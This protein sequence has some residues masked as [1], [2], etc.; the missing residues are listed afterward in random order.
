[1]AT[2]EK[3]VMHCNEISSLLDAY[4][5]K[6]QQALN[7]AHTRE[8][9]ENNTYY[10]SRS[11]YSTEHN[12][13]TNEN[14]RKKNLRY[15]KTH[16]YLDATRRLL[17]SI[18]D[19]H[20]FRMRQHYYDAT[21]GHASPDRYLS[22]TPEELISLLENIFSQ[23]HEEVLQLCNAFMP[24]AVS[25]AVG[26]VVPPFRK[27]KYTRIAS[28]RNKLL[29]IA[30]ALCDCSDLCSRQTQLDEALATA[31]GNLEENHAL[32]IQQ[33]RESTNESLAYY[34]EYYSN[35]LHTSVSCNTL[36]TQMPLQIG[37]YTYPSTPESIIR[38]QSDASDESS[39]PL[40]TIPVTCSGFEKSIV[41]RTSGQSCLAEFYSQLALDILSNDPSTNIAMIDIAGLGRNYYALAELSGVSHFSVMST[42]DQ[43]QSYLETAE[44]SISEVYAG[45]ELAGKTYIFVDDCVCNIPDRCVESL[46]RIIANG[47]ACGVYVIASVKETV[48]ADRRWNSILGGIDASKFNVSSNRLLIGSG[49]ITLASS[50]NSASRVSL[51]AT[52]LEHVSKSADVIPLWKTFPDA[53]RWQTHSSANGISV[54][55]GIDVQ[56]G[57]P[58]Y[59]SLTEEKP[60]ALIVGDVDVGKSSALH[61]LTL[62]MMANY[63]PSEVRIAI[64]DFKDGCEFNTYVMPLPGAETRGAS[65]DE[66]DRE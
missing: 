31:Q 65:D 61:C 36:Q 59:F 37:Q 52:R 23:L 15:S 6:L 19:P 39:Q 58:S 43:V 11:G 21:I 10:A 22:T 16:E 29:G 30:V 12:D 20:W 17:D 13:L 64:G 18:N 8:H 56:T 63:A 34:A 26:F 42:A 46:A 49:F 40:F 9:S 24:P 25:N 48:S 54:P 38:E 35:Q 50:A 62:Q 45:R 28:L 53:T 14:N 3:A 2:F 33:I 44:R 47:S 60:Y 51:I 66:I 7:T 5:S 55:I 41:F 27:A 32:N 57:S 1:M 4:R